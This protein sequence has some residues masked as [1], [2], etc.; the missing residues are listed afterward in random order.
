MSDTEQQRHTVRGECAQLLEPENV[1]NYT[2]GRMAEFMATY[3]W[4]VAVIKREQNV[5][6]NEY[7]PTWRVWKFIDRIT[8]WVPSE[9]A[10]DVL[11]WNPEFREGDTVR[12]RCDRLRDWSKDWYV[13][14]YNPVPLNGHPHAGGGSQ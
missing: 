1:D 11:V 2:V 4:S 9:D 7:G 14:P 6:K 8:P 3:G 12:L 5:Y 13:H 10:Y